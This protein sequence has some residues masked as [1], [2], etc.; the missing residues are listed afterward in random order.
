MD[1]PKP[2]ESL[3]DIGRKIIGNNY[4]M[5]ITEYHEKFTTEYPDLT[6]EDFYK[7]LMLLATKTARYMDLEKES[8]VQINDLYDT[9]KQHEA[10]KA[11]FNKA[12]NFSLNTDEGDVFLRLWREGD[13][14]QIRKEWPEYY[15]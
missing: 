12:I 8:M 15:E 4:H 6:K 13:F 3:D 7:S 11:E 2:V 14:E 1:L 9:L 5:D 10:D